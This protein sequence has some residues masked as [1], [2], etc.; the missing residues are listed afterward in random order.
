MKTLSLAR[1][2]IMMVIGLPGAGKS[3]FARQFSDTFSIAS[4]SSDRIRYE[5]F[6]SPQF[7][8]DENE[9]VSR[10]QDYMAEEL[11]KSGRSFL[12]DGNCN[13]KAAR[14]KIAQL[15]KDNGYNT[16][17][18][19]V[20]TD[21]ATAK[22][23]ATKRNPKKPDDKFS[24]SITDTLFD[25]FTQRFAPPVKEDHVVISGKHVYSTQARTVLRKLAMPHVEAANATH[26]DAEPLT[27]VPKRPTQPSVRSRR[28][29]V[30]R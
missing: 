19:W 27:P 24:A 5:L 10:M 3:F 25:T 17:L 12:I 30:I 18:I 22:V 7:S 14:Q 11:A 1:P 4:V 28:D 23:R 8:S 20:Q 29:V 9:I 13:S 6:A 15:A 2:L 21:P 16:L 26:K